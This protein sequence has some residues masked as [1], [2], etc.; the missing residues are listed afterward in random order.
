MTHLTSMTGTSGPIPADPVAAL[1]KAAGPGA[2]VARFVAHHPEHADALREFAATEQLLRIAAPTPPPERLPPG[3]RLGPFQVVRFVTAGGMGEI[4]EARQLDLKRSVAL[5]VIRPDKADEHARARFQ[6]EREVLAALHQTHIVPVFAAG[7][8]DGLQY[9]AMQYIQGAALS[10]VVNAL[11]NRETLPP[12]TTNLSLGELVKTLTPRPADA[13][14]NPQRETT[15]YRQQSSEKAEPSWPTVAGTVGRVVNNDTTRAP[16]TKEYYRTVAAALADAADALEAAHARGICHRDLKPSNL[17]VEPGGNCWLI[18]FGLASPPLAASTLTPGDDADARLT[19]A[20]LGTPAYMAPEE[21]ARSGDPRL[22]DVWGLGATLYE[23]L[24]FRPPHDPATGTPPLASPPP[25]RSLDDRIPR[26]LDTICCKALKYEPTER[27]SS[28]K[29]FGDDL[30]RWLTG[31]TTEARPGWGTLRPMRLWAWRNKA[32]AATIGLVFVLIGT[33]LYSAQ[34]QLRAQKRELAF[35][36][37]QRLRLTERRHGW[38]EMA[39]AMARELAELDRNAD[40]RDQAA[41]VLSGLDARRVREWSLGGSSVVFDGDGRRMLIGGLSPEPD[42][43]FA[44]EPTRLWSGGLDDPTPYRFSGSGPAAFT[45]D[46]TPLQ[47]V[48]GEDGTLALWDVGKDRLVR[49]FKLPALKPTNHVTLALSADGSLVAASAVLADGQNLLTVWESASGK[50][51]HDF[52]QNATALAFSPDSRFL[53]A[54]DDNGKVA[55]WNLDTGK[56]SDLRGAGRATVHAVAFGRNPWRGRELH[57]GDEWLLAAGDA[58]GTVAVWEVG[59]ETLRTYSHG[60]YHDVY[61][62]AFSPDGMTVAS[63]GRN[64][65]RLWDLATGRILLGVEGQDYATGL[66][67]SPDGTKLAVSRQKVFK[68]ASV[69]IWNLEY[70]RGQLQLRGLVARPEMIRFSPDGKLVAALSHDWQIGVWDLRTGFLR[71]VL[72]C[73]RGRFADN[74]ALAF[75]PDSRQ[76]AASAGREARIWDLEKGTELKTWRLPEGLQDHLA[77]EPTGKRL[78]SVRL[79][80]S[81]PNVP[82]YGT[83]LTK[84]P[85]LFQVRNLLGPK[86]AEPLVT[87]E[88]FRRGVYGSVISPN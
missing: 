41:A 86:P 6:R 74:V 12:G 1:G 68:D 42:R 33:V 48:A 58:G 10:H 14:A 50:R 46:G 52:K 44:G 76:L 67:F 8:A 22:W 34:A 26:D 4:Y 37:L 60:S 36:E 21:C 82:P 28:A 77:Y 55:V 73:P 29:A 65:V 87:I 16:L 54:G 38:S 47:F 5:K 2:V 13:L 51:L 45:A 32:W 43:K 7:E 88:E 83:D 66:A 17:M 39:W 56:R 31:H 35:I 15:N 30:R 85:R 3:T 57:P 20:C 24:T 78:I 62:V 70:G 61:A 19:R 11:R 53:A 25:P 71:Y 69:S 81:D 40:V 23:L 27:Y 80:T 18:D 84:Y 49:E 63:G 59:T 75:S 64:E 79:E 72:Q 9:F